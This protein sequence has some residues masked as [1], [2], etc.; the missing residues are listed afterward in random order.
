MPSVAESAVAEMVERIVAGFDP[1]RVIL[2]GSLVRGEETHDSDVDLLVVFSEIER[3]D[4]RRLTVDIR[5]ALADVP[6]PK[7]IVVADPEEI[8]RRGGVPGTVL[9]EALREGRTLY[10]RT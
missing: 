8:S 6:F 2:F 9:H 4:K 7:D 3:E 10:E 5:R 1:V